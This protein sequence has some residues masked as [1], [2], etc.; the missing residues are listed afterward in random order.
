MRLSPREHT[1]SVP[2][3]NHLPRK[4]HLFVAPGSSTEG[5]AS[6]LLVFPELHECSQHVGSGYRLRLTRVLHPSLDQ[7]LYKLLSG[8]H[9]LVNGVN[10]ECQEEAD[11][12]A[13]AEGDPQHLVLAQTKALSDPL[14]GRLMPQQDRAGLLRLL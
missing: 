1:I 7:L 5:C 13:F 2:T 10:Y 4:D 11:Q 8:V 12:Q 9:W 14:D 3:R 6:L